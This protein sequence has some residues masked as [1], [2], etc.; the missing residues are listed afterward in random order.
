[1][2]FMSECKLL[3]DR[4]KKGQTEKIDQT[5]ERAFLG[6]DEK[7]LKFSF[8]VKAKGE[9]YL[10]DDHLIIRLKAST[11][12]LMPCSI[13]NEMIESDL[14]VDHFYHAVPVEEIECAIFDYQEFL[15]EALLLELPQTVECNDGNC[16]ERATMAPYIRSSD[17]ANFPFKDIDDDEKS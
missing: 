6:P 4:L 13:C 2:G 12:V 16:P 15:R 11:K 1:M 14:N 8:A 3:I 10:T 17:D 9:A 7:E 5:L